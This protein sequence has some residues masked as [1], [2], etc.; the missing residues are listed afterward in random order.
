L[1][2]LAEAARKLTTGKVEA[3]AGQRRW[4]QRRRQPNIDA[5]RAYAKWLWID[6]TD[7]QEDWSLSYGFHIPPRKIVAAKATKLK[8]GQAADAVRLSS[9]YGVSDNP[10]WTPTM[11]IALSDAVTN[12]VRKGKG[13]GGR[14]DRRSSQGQRRVAEAVRLG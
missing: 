2:E 10:A 9:Q 4:L 7:Y 1:D 8:S 3:V 12:I 5:A 6:R 14:A 13:P 11:Q